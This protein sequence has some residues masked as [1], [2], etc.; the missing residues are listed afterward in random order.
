MSEALQQLGAS[1]RRDRR[2]GIGCDVVLRC[3][4]TDIPAQL[5]VVC[6]LSPV[7]SKALTG[8]F[9]ETAARAIELPDVD[10]AHVAFAL[11]HCCGAVEDI[12]PQMALPLLSLA[13]RW[14]MK[15]LQSSCESA[16]RAMLD[17]SNAKAI[18]EG[19]RAC[20]CPDLAA[21]AQLLADDESTVL[22]SLSA[23]KLRLAHAVTSLREDAARHAGAARGRIA[24]AEAAHQLASASY[25]RE[26]E[27]L[28]QER[29]AATAADC[30]T[31]PYPHP[32]RRKLRVRPNAD[33]R[34]RWINPGDDL[35]P[36]QSDGLQ[37]YYDDLWGALQ[38][39]RPGDVIQLER[40][41]HEFK[42]MDSVKDLLHLRT[43]VQIVG[44]APGGAVTLSGGWENAIFQVDADVR[45]ADLTLEFAASQAEVAARNG[46]GRSRPKS[47][48]ALMA[49]G[50]G[51]HDEIAHDLLKVG[52]GGRLWMKTCVLRQGAN[53]VTVRAGGSLFAIATAFSDAE[54]SAVAVHPLAERVLLS[55]CTIVGCALGQRLGSGK[56]SYGS[57]RSEGIPWFLPGECGAV[58]IRAKYI[59]CEVEDFLDFEPTAHVEVVGSHLEGNHGYA[60]SYRTDVV[61]EVRSYGETFYE[62]FKTFPTQAELEQLFVLNDN[63]I[64]GNGT[65]LMAEVDSEDDGQGAAEIAPDDF[66]THSSLLNSYP[67][68]LW[69]TDR[70]GRSGGNG[71]F[72][73]D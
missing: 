25:E 62:A 13:D 24:E 16:L 37:V 27:R 38:D 33:E 26:L 59:S 19:A 56:R 45:L 5:S 60:F 70:K 67:G 42:S 31:G 12:D 39:A 6:A 3:G 58:E 8:A 23:R 52:D 35:P 17:A 2:C 1:L 9:K 49:N 65:Q 21:D 68:G 61:R 36:R 18:A 51:C 11:D 50:G 15:P 22:Q 44:E 57:F 48:Y 28:L 10:P 43:S 41:N 53:L 55:G 7:L 63:T 66:N 4:D 54:G 14:Q 69:A 34:W 40:G 29:A 47:A 64:V 20:N 32:P 30:R 73:N 72:A 46:G 71:G